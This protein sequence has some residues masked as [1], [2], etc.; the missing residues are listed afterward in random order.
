[1]LLSSH[2]GHKKKACE[3]E[4][5]CIGHHAESLQMQPM[6]WDSEGL[7]FIIVKQK[8]KVEQQV[9][10]ELILQITFKGNYKKTLLDI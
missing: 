4:A 10:S 7:L 3:K 2:Q 6:S 8:G 1:M 5:Q 9:G